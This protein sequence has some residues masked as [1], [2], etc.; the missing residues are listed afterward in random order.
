MHPLAIDGAIIVDPAGDEPLAQV[1]TRE[2]VPV[3]TT[4][5]PVDGPTIHPWV[6]NDH[7]PV[8]TLMLDHFHGR[9]Y[10]RPALMVTTARRSYVADIVD[11]YRGWCRDHGMDP[12][13]VELAE[14]PDEHAAE[15]AAECLLTQRD[16]P[17]A[18]YASYDRLALGVLQQA[19][20]LGLSV[21]GDLGLASAVDGD[22]LHWSDP[23]ITAVALDAPR[24][25][26]AAVELLV[27]L[28]EGR[29]PASTQIIFP[30]RL[31]VR[32]ST[33]ARS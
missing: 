28:V 3:V 23:R 1:L 11:S 20:K 30:G 14:P 22:A 29:R 2:G 17:D 12:I 24:I 16:R 19:R 13:I 15:Q 21:P 6:D 25:G 33:T 4:G 26:R 5:R 31:A 32:A 8:T 27:A 7:G 10:E 9:G 18:V